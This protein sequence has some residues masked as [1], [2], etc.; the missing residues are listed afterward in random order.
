VAGE[1]FYDRTITVLVHVMNNFKYNFL[2]IPVFLCF[3]SCS[4]TNCN[5]P[6]KRFNEFPKVISLT[7]RNIP[8]IKNDFFALQMGLK[9]SLLIFCDYEN[10]PHFHIYELPG[11]KSIGSFGSQGKGPNDIDYPVFW[12]QIEKTENSYLIWFFQSN[13]MKQTCIDINKYLNSDKSIP[14]KT[15]EMPPEMDASINVLKLNDSVLI[16][17]GP[18]AKG[19][20]FIYNS[21]SDYFEWQSFN[22]CGIDDIFLEKLKSNNLLSEYKMGK[23][24]I[25]PDESKFVKSYIYLPVISVYNNNAEL[26]F[27]IKNEQFDLPEI[28]NNIFSQESNIYYTNIFLTDSFI[29]ALN[30]NCSLM[31]MGKSKDVEIDVFDWNGN[32]VCRYKLNEGIV[33]SGA[34]A[35]DE[36]NNMIYT[37]NP[38]NDNS[39]YSKFQI[40]TN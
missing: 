2:I 7:G 10:S 11:F 32:A 13:L 19:E 25:K 33:A 3:N 18:D 38:K 14:E 29:Y 21:N 31:Y 26:L 15:F 28:E 35:V 12:G 20:F 1:P 30:Q 34:F 23:I 36:P 17:T 4:D 27:S 22:L 8:E 5:I 6:E 16:G 24:K 40:N 9:D 37:I 39:Y